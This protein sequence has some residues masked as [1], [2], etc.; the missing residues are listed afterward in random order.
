MDFCRI[1]MCSNAAGTIRNYFDVASALIPSLAAPLEREANL[2]ALVARSL[3]HCPPDLTVRL[4]L[5]LLPIE[6]QRGLSPVLW[7]NR[8]RWIL[9]WIP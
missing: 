3:E 6:R 4:A 2:P 1:L 8:Q 9:P 5:L 7:P